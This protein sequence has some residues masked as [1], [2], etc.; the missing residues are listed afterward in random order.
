MIRHALRALT[1]SSS[2]L[3]AITASAADLAPGGTFVDDDGSV[4]EGA[5]EALYAADITRGCDPRGIYFCPERALTRAEMATFLVRALRLP[6]ATGDYFVDDDDSIHHSAINALAEAGI[7]RGCNPPANDRFCPAD[8]VRREQLA[9][10]L[11]RALQLSRADTASAFVDIEGSP[12]ATDISA[13]AA[14]GIT[15]GCNPPENDRFCP[16]PAVTRAEVATFL[17]R[18]LPDLT[19]LT[20]PPRVLERVSRFTTYR[21]CCEPR[22]RNIQLMADAVD[23]YV[24]LPGEIFSINEVV[25][26]RTRAKGYVEAPYLKDG[27]LACC[28]VGGGTSQFGTTIYNA[29]F[30]GGFEDI[31]HQPHSRY[32]NRYP[33]GIEATLGYPNLDVKFRNDTDG[34]VVIRTS[35]TATSITVSLWG[36]AGGWQMTGYHPVGARTS[37]IQ[38]INNAGRRV[39]A[40]VSGSATFSGGGEVRITRTV[41]EPDGT[42]RSRSWYWRYLSDADVQGEVSLAGSSGLVEE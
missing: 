18:A 20:P 6:P 42:R 22:V 17:V 3:L 4:H 7:T 23:G 25:G 33:L 10:F 39:S 13:L 41:T 36:D 31:A 16:W 2:L 1:F 19:P 32:I 11:V 34:I 37:R 24:V 30:W 8:P 27:K 14:S 26:P 35:Y 9:S 40:T 38:V 5:I 15:R 21:N 28:A 12:H 29:I